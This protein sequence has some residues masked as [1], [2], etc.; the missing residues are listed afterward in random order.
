[1]SVGF[2]LVENWV[3]L[4]MNVTLLFQEMQFNRGLNQAGRES[5]TGL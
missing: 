1:M 3:V 2:S 4:D 5:A